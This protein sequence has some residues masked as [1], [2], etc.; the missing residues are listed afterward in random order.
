[1]PTRAIVLVLAAAWF[2]AACAT[3]GASKPHAAEAPATPGDFTISE[4]ARAPSELR[5]QFTRAVA[6]LEQERFEDGIALLREVTEKAPNLTAA[7]LDL[8]IAYARIGDL[9]Q[10]QASLERALAQ[11]PRHPVAWNELGMVQRRAGRFPEAR[12]SYEQALAAYPSFLPARRN[13]AVLCDVYLADRACAL[14][15]VEHTVQAAP[16]D[17]DAARWLADLRARAN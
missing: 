4:K 3:S 5:S 2:C 1:M 13:L 12:K 15:Q 7:H 8:G 11:S 14:E 16:D 6:L 9:A 17:A 10:A